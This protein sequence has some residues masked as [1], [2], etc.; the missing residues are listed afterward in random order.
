M[1]KKSNAIFKRLSKPPP[2]VLLTLVHFFIPFFLIIA[3]FGVVFWIQALIASSFFVLILY[4]LFSRLLNNTFQEKPLKGRS[5][6][7]DLP[8]LEQ[9]VPKIE[10]ASASHPAPFMYS[11][12]FYG[13]KKIVLSQVFLERF[14]EEEKTQALQFQ[15]N[16][17]NLNHALLF[18]QLSYVLF[19]LFF[20]VHYTGVLF[21]KLR[22]SFLKKIVD[23]FFLYFI[24]GP[25][26]P[27]I[28]GLFFR[29]DR[30]CPDPLNHIDLMKKFHSRF[31][32][33]STKSPPLFIHPLFFTNPL[34]KTYS[35]F[36]LHPT[37]PKR[38]KRMENFFS[39]R[40]AKKT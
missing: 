16:Y 10:V 25:L 14:S 19:I 5:P 1:K 33:F 15:K 24:A 38:I 40:E 27:I 28:H 18:T 21:Q 32:A 2:W 11:F 26:S 30:G 17:F 6:W 31:S 36:S 3:V 7:I 37:V 34:T 35:C 29:M 23:G 13:Q 22:L 20:P 8:F 4:K 9:A 12:N 39:R